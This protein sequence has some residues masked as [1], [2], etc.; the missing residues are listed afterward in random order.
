MD[1]V[2]IAGPFANIPENV[3][4]VDI[5]GLGDDRPATSLRTEHFMARVDECWFVSSPDTVLSSADVKHFF[6]RVSHV[7][8]IPFHVVVT[9]AEEVLD[10]TGKQDKLRQSVRAKLRHWC[11]L[12][13]LGKVHGPE[14]R[15][16]LSKLDA[17]VRQ[18]VEEMVDA[19]DI[20][21][22]ACHPSRPARGLDH[23]IE[24]LRTLGNFQEQAFA[25]AEAGVAAIEQHMRDLTHPPPRPRAIVSAEVLQA[26]DAWQANVEDLIA[27]AYPGDHLLDGFHA[28]VQRANPRKFHHKTVQALMDPA[29]CGAFLSS[30][31]GYIDVNLMVATEWSNRTMFVR[32]NLDRLSHAIAAL[33]DQ[34]GALCRHLQYLLH[35]LMQAVRGGAVA[36]VRARL[37][38]AGAYNFY[39]RS[40]MLTETEI[41]QAVV[42][43]RD[44]LR[45]ALQHLRGEVAIAAEAVRGG[46]GAPV[47]VVVEGENADIQAA[48]T[49]ALQV[50]A[51]PA[52][53]LEPQPTVITGPDEEEWWN[54][55]WRRVCAALV[56]AEEGFER[57]QEISLT[58]L[59]I[60]D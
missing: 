53:E 4:L 54:L 39:R 24:R 29:R 59:S 37:I 43:L 57:V 58:D 14:P 27:A 50:A 11:A 35:R 25:A 45:T 52:P 8:G 10:D 40:Y 2:H 19:V 34:S 46:C 9:K 6:T 5:P 16:P 3:V 26:V 49:H 22:M 42:P 21:F 33:P 32:A 51:A 7:G 28:A 36:A 13:L 17:E 12:V 30:T 41:H 44:E 23:L 18:L 1:H 60:M 15:D 20:A 48:V 56:Q 47:P 31:A 55:M 38:Q